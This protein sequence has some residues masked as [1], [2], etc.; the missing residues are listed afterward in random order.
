MA[1]KEELSD[2]LND[3]L[4]L[5]Y[6]DFAKMTKDDLEILLKV[7]AEP[8]NLIRIGWK[9]LRDKAKKEILEELMGRPLLDDMLKDVLPKEGVGEG[10]GP[11]GLGIL[12]RARERFRGIFAEKESK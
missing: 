10:K 7:V 12:P 1:T 11:L 5:E 4:G 9:N 2:R 3:L 8:S 6:V